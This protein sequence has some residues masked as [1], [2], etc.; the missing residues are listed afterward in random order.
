MEFVLVFITTLG[1][2]APKVT[3][4][5]HQTE[6]ACREV[7]TNSEKLILERIISKSWVTISSR[8]SCIP[9]IIS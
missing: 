2:S 1:S 3:F 6:Q 7:A 9:A 4:S 8:Y 5:I